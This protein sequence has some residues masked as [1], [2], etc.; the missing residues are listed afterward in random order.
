MLGSRTRPGANLLVA[1][2][3]LASTGCG[4]TK[5]PGRSAREGD[6]AVGT[7][8]PDVPA[9]ELVVGGAHACVRRPPGEALCWGAN[10]S[11]QLGRGDRAGALAFDPTPRPIEGL[12]PLKHLALGLNHSCAIT[13]DEKV[14]CWGGNFNLQIGKP[15]DWHHLTR[16]PTP[17]GVAGVPGAHSLALGGAHSC[18]LTH[19]GRVFC[20]GDNEHCSVG[21]TPSYQGMFDAS[22]SAVGRLLGVRQLDLG[23]T[24]SCALA[25]DGRALCWGFNGVGQLGRTSRSPLDLSL[26]SDC[27]P[28]PPQGLA[29]V[30]Q[31]ALGHEHTCALT[32]DGRVWCWGGNH[33]GQLG[34]KATRNSPQGIPKANPT[35]EPI[36]GLRD[37]RQIAL[38][39]SHT[40]ALTNEGKVLCWGG[41]E[42][43]QLGS[44]D[45]AG[46]GEPNETPRPVEGLEGVRQIALGF[47][48]S[49]ALTAENRVYCWGDN[50]SGQLGYAAA[51]ED[52][53]KSAVPRQISGLGG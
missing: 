3:A 13:D 45:A 48:V 47:L 14:H 36:D 10:Q 49:C 50:R 23:M 6:A 12:R 17:R 41:N 25:G 2:V 39:L 33:F 19:E 40:C 44:P 30:R 9:F 43:G 37:I 38:G 32:Q 18:A 31:I 7:I 46:G 51:D 21:R 26:P 42:A 28:T 15:G 27:E 5:Q 35:P 1:C 8:A 24:H 53:Q 16:N 11:G 20:W 34:R 22:P 29:G 4:G 52:S